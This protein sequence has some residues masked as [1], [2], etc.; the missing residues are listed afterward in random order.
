M[1]KLIVPLVAAV[2]SLAALP[3]YSADEPGRSGDP[4]SA[5]KPVQ[6]KEKVKAQG[7]HEEGTGASEHVTA[8]SKA[9]PT[10]GEVTSPGAAG[11]QEPGRSGDPASAEKR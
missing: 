4:A 8:E 11:A 9:T 3:S 2:F 10:G 5:E 6:Q 1:K 7:A